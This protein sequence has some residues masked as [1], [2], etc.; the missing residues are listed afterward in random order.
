VRD[1]ILHRVAD[2]EPAAIRELTDRYG[3]LVFALARRFSFDQSE[4]DDAVQEIFVALWK[5]AARFDPAIG[6]EDTFVAMVA[7]RRLIDRRRRISRR[8]QAA[9]TDQEILA[10]SAAAPI[11]ADKSENNELGAWAMEQLHKLRP[12]Q[13]M[14]IRMSILR[15]LS[16]EQIAQATGMPLGTVKTHV[17]RGIMALRESAAATSTIRQ[18]Q[19]E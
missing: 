11:E 12:E 15:G 4:V 17:R 13:Q 6:S 19:E 9:P 16:H 2:G 7:R 10:A 1:S 8:I 5:S 3:G 14:V 18:R